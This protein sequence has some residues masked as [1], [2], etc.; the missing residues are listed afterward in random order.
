[1]ALIKGLTALPKAIKAAR[2]GAGKASMADVLERYKPMEGVAFILRNR[3]LRILTGVMALEVLLIDAL[4]FVLI[5]SLITD[6]L[7]AAPT[8]L[9]LPLWA[10]AASAGAAALAAGARAAKLVNRGGRPELSAP[11]PR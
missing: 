2:A 7:G 6:A 1:L 10:V 9:L 5:P 11:S 8:T 4:P 3:T